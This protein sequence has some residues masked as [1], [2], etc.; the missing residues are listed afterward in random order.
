M[1]LN[2]IDMLKAIVNAPISVK[3]KKTIS[4][5]FV[6]KIIL[7]TTLWTNSADDNL[8]FFLFFLTK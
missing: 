1:L 5:E 6:E 4:S 8:I 3:M 7:L 2:A